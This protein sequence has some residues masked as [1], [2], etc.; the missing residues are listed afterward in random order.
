MTKHELHK[1]NN[2]TN[3]KLHQIQS[4]PNMKKLY[5]I[6]TTVNVKIVNVEIC[7]LTRSP[8]ILRWCTLMISTL[9]VLPL[10]KC[11]MWDM[12]K[13]SLNRQFCDFFESLCIK[14]DQ[15]FPQ[16]WPLRALTKEV[17][18]C[19][20]TQLRVHALLLLPEVWFDQ[21]WRAWSNPTKEVVIAHAL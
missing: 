18:L 4:N 11:L 16:M 1:K 14:C 6:V 7:L 3:H 17:T 12:P 10:R 2:I 15:F 9:R 20:S 13:K 5:T 8:N 19:I 21:A